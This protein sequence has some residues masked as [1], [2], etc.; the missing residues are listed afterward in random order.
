MATVIKCVFIFRDQTGTGWEEIHYWNS[1]SDNPV[2]STRLTNLVDV[3]APVRALLL[4]VDCA[5][6][7]A[8]VSY[9]RPGAVASLSKKFY[10]SGVAGKSSVSA[11]VSLTGKW[12][13]ASTTRHKKTYL[14]GVWDDVENNGEYHPELPEAAGFSDRITEW[15]QL[16]INGGYGWTTKSIANSR[17]G[18]V[19]SYTATP[20]GIVTFTL[21]APGMDGIAAGKIVE[22]AF[23]KINK[24]NSPLNDTLLVEVI[25]ATHL[26]TVNP[27]AAGPFT[28]K[29]KF[30]YRA[31]EFV[32]YN[33]LYDL[34]IGRRQ[35]GRPIGQLPG[36]RKARARY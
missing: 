33:Q 36:R 18:V 25:D 22:V 13:D 8:R 1:T 23:S 30:N 14:R 26:K 12:T 15:K 17:N 32:N 11:S 5:V 7:G 34:A 9:P 16:L 24:S 35:Q 19:N 27:I 4:G 29:G 2:L 31:V 28:S 20:E 3:I 10:L 6:I 21:A